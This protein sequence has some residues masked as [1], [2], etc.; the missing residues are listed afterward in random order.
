MDNLVPNFLSEVDADDTV[1]LFYIDIL[2]GYENNENRGILLLRDEFKFELL[3]RK[4]N[5][6]QQLKIRN[7]KNEF[8]RYTK[9][10]N[11]LFLNYIVENYE[12]KE[13]KLIQSKNKFGKP[14]L[15][16]RSYQFNLSDEEGIVCLAVGFNEKMK[17]KEIGIDLANPLDIERFKLSKLENFY[18]VDFRSIFSNEEINSLDSLFNTL[19]YNERLNILSQIWALKESYCKYLGVGI[20]AGMENYQFLNIRKVQ[21]M[22]NNNL[23]GVELK[24]KNKLISN[25]IELNKIEGYEPYNVCIKIPETKFICSIF[26]HY[27]YAFLVK[28]EIEEF[29]RQNIMNC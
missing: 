22:E 17:N 14:T 19:Q 10:I 4:L 6:K 25:K 8:D 7:I 5:L 12:E 21:N 27:K 23:R 3:L 2:N 28:I 29:I 26:S 18:K 16:N 15:D 9:L 11:L 13:V 24:S 1:C 20:T